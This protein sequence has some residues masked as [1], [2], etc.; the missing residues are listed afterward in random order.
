[1]KRSL[2]KI[3]AMSVLL[4]TMVS[5]K[6][7]VDYSMLDRWKGVYTV[8]A[9]SYFGDAQEPPVTDYDEEWTVTV[10]K[11]EG[12][13]TKLAFTGIGGA[14]ALTVYATLDPE[15]MTISFEPG[16]V[17]GDILEY[18][19]VSIYYGTDDIISFAGADIAQSYI[20]AAASTKLTGTLSSDGGIIIDRFAEIV[21]GPSVWDVFKTTWVKQK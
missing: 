11:V 14:T 9:E 4:L 8:T 2:L 20:D 5:C 6:D 10:T 19:A 17:L 21:E 13:E 1:M 12:S 18:G 7:K 15:A 16:Q 3:S